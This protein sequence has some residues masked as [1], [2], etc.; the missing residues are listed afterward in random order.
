MDQVDAQ[1]IMESLARG[2]ADEDRVL[3]YTAP[4]RL[5]ASPI[6]QMLSDL[7]EVRSGISKVR[8]LN[9]GYG[10]GKSHS[11]SVVRKKALDPT[12]A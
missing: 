11:L 2:V 5:R 4:T 8:F 1:A 12:Q 7:E 3:A 9:G 10:E 6:A